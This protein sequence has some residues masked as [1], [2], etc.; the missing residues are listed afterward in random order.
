MVTRF[1]AVNNKV[2]NTFLSALVVTDL[3]EVI[4]KEIEAQIEI[5]NDSGDV[6]NQRP[7]LIRAVQLIRASNSEREL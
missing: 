2:H 6:Y 4:A 3:S 1:E 5:L 7:G